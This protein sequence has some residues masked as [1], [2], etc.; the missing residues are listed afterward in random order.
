ME[1]GVIGNCAHSA[2]AEAG[3]IVWL[4]WPRMDSSPVFGSLLDE[5]KGGRFEVEAI[6][7]R[8]VQQEYVENTNILRTVFTSDSGCFE[9]L[10]FAPR[11]SKHGRPFKPRMLV[12]ILR[13]LKG[14]PLV[15]VRIDPTYHYGRVEITR[16]TASNHIEFNGLPQYAERSALGLIPVYNSLSNDVK[17]IPAVKDFQKSLQNPWKKSTATAVRKLLGFVTRRTFNHE[18][19]SV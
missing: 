2:L 7:L 4:C 16:W 14:E 19:K 17:H 5:E 6:D 1:Y 3:R 18:Y 11:F 9:L 12:R 13:P 15:R 10:D 8:D